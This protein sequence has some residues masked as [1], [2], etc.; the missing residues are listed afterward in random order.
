MASP[1]TATAVPLATYSLTFQVDQAPGQTISNTADPNTVAS[2]IQSGA[3]DSGAQYTGRAV[4][5]TFTPLFVQVQG[6]V[7]APALAPS[8]IVGL[9]VSSSISYYVR[10]VQTAPAPVD[11][12]PLVIQTTLHADAS[13][14]GSGGDANPV[15]ASFEITSLNI[16]D[17][18]L[19]N[20]SAASC[21]SPSE[22]SFTHAAS[23][24][25][26]QDIQVIIAA[27]GTATGF[28]AVDCCTGH[29]TFQAI[30]D[31]T[32]QIDPSFAY[33]DDFAVVFSPNLTPAAAVP[34]PSS[35]ALLA[36]GLLAFC[37]PSRGFGLAGVVRRYR[38]RP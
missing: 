24:M 22:M 26:G 21:T 32:I 6:G 8:S 4:T 28:G 7:D 30:A 10:V 18:E 13:A 37:L 15:M 38:R 11:V 34:E 14:T 20:C 35:I 2:I 17:F 27:A 36:I 3:N 29:A 12:V 33:L 1:A 31:P 25:A 16:F 5:S 23:A 9:S 19:A